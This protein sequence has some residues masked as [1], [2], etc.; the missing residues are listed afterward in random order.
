MDK[1]QGTMYDI[2]CGQTLHD[3]DSRQRLRIHDTIHDNDSNHDT[4][5]DNDSNHD[6]I[7]DTITADSRFKEITTRFTI[8]LS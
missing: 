1:V 3:N 2:D 6:T 8:L 5:H 4:I 7:P